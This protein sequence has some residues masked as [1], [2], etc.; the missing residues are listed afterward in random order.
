MRTKKEIRKKKQEDLQFIISAVTSELDEIAYLRYF[1][2]WENNGGMGWFFTECVEITHKI[3]L[4]EGSAYMKWLNYW[5][6]TTEGDDF[7]F[8]SEFT[9][10]TSFDWYHMNKAKAEFESRYEKD[11]CT[12]EQI[13]ERMGYLLNSFEVA[14]DRDDLLDRVVNFAAMQRTKKMEREKAKLK[15][16]DPRVQQVIDTLK[17]L[18]VDG[19]SMEHIIDEV[20]MTQQMV[21]QLHF[22]KIS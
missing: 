16:N 22:D 13:S 7:Q 15:V 11:E 4:T 1:D 8:F 19:E 10:E 3:M 18:E 12:K 2:A 14:E 6:E 17:E 20:G 21:K 9:G 5:K